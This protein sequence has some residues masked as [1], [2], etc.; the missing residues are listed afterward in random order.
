MKTDRF[1]KQ[2]LKHWQTATAACGLLGAL[3]SACVGADPISDGEQVVG[4]DEEVEVLEEGPVSPLPAADG[5]SD[6][7]VGGD[8]IAKILLDNGSKFMFIGGEGGI[9]VLEGLPAGAPGFKSFSALQNATVADMYMAISEP[10]SPIP[11]AIKHSSVD[12]GL[13]KQGWMRAEIAAGNYTAPRGN[14]TDSTFT[15]AV[16][17]TGYNDR[18]TPTLRLNQYVGDSPYFKQYT[19]CFG[20]NFPGGCPKFYRYEVGG[21][22]GSVWYN[23]DQYFTRVA[24]CG[25]GYHPTI[26]TNY[27]IVWAHPGPTISVW[28]R[29]PNNANWELEFSDDVNPNQVGWS[30]TWHPPTLANYDWRTRIELAKFGDF[31]DIGHAVEDLG[32]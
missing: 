16:Q 5:N 29:A 11:D 26:T 28:K 20:T 1:F 32:I 15:Q 12:N 13:G 18:G 10:G 27:G 7:Q 31:F 8:V 21:N 24:V 3:L 17:A 25:L 19:E 2:T 9:S 4:N 14:C 30:W 23:V 22:N 6:V